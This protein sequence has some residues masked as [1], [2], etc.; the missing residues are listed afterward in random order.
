MAPCQTDSSVG[1]TRADSPLNW[2]FPARFSSLPLA[3]RPMTEASPPP[4]GAGDPENLPTTPPA[5]DN[6][7][8]VDPPSAG[9]LM[10]LFVVPLVI[11]VMIVMVCLMFNWLAHLGTRPEQLVD[12]LTRLNPG[13]WQKALTIAN[14]LCDRQQAELRRDP[15]LASRLS[16][17]LD[18]QIEQGSFE[19]EPLKLRVY[20][21]LAL[22]VFEI[23]EGLPVLVKAAETQ[24]DLRELEVRKTAIEAIA[25]RA[26]GIPNGPEILQR[27]DP[28]MQALFTAA[29]QQ[30]GSSEEV[31]LNAQLRSRAAYTLGVIGGPESQNRLARMLSD[32]DPTVHLMPRPVCSA[33]RRPLRRAS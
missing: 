29:D 20:L 4:A 19:P 18:E 13:S 5:T 15:A 14:L 17:I 30:G 6:L 16:E 10:Q 23:E 25:R 22:G 7:P 33:R 24:R 28:L 32:S 1:L 26:E 27:H 8:P 3:T 9:F 12:D 21:C 31:E 11:V 2:G